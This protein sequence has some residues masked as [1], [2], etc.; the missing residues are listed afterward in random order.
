MLE[1]GPPG[2]DEDDVSM[3]AS[4]SKPGLNAFIGLKRVLKMKVWRERIKSFKYF[5]AGNAVSLKN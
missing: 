5:T 4:R 1:V 3:Q 2:L